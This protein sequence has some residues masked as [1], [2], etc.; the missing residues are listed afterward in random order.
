[1]C[2]LLAVK[3]IRR[4][5]VREEKSNLGILIETLGMT[6]VSAKFNPKYL[7]LVQSRAKHIQSDIII[8]GVTDVDADNLT[9][10]IKIPDLKGYLQSMFK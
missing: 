10:Y 3:K 4:K 7:T 5:T 6:R 9:N 2:F 8:D 1:M